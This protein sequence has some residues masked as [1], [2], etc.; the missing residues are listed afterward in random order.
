MYTADMADATNPN[1]EPKT[2][3]RVDKP[4]ITSAVAHKI[5]NI[6]SIALV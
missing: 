6:C 4:R 3:P 1:T 2:A 5:M